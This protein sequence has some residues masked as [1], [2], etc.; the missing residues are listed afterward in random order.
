MKRKLVLVMAEFLGTSAFGQS[1]RNNQGLATHEHHKKTYGENRAV[2]SGR[3]S[4]VPELVQCDRGDDD[5]SDDHLLHPF[6]PS[7][8]LASHV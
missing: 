4:P 8:L 1:S 3:G 2:V 6:G 7:H 5:A